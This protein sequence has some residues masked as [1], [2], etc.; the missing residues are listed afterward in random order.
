[1]VYSRLYAWQE[2]VFV[3]VGFF[4]KVYLILFAGGFC[5]VLAISQLLVRRGYPGKWLFILSLF[6]LAVWEEFGGISKY[7]TGS[8]FPFNIYVVTFPAF[9]VSIATFYLLCRRILDATPSLRP[10]DAMHAIMPLYSLLLLLPYVRRPLHL[11]ALMETAAFRAMLYGFVTKAIGYFAVLLGKALR[12]LGSTEKKNRNPL[13]ATSGFIAINFLIFIAWF[14]ELIF[15]IGGIDYIT[16][17]FNAVIILIFLS[18]TRNPDYF[19]RITEQAERFKYARSLIA[20]VDA[21]KTLARLSSLMAQEK[22]Y[23]DPGLCLESLAKRVALGP[24]QLSEL[25]NSKAGKSFLEFVTEY[26]VA[27]AQLLLCN[28]AGR[29]V[30]DIACDVGFNSSSAFYSSFKKIAGMTPT[31]YRDRYAAHPFLPVKR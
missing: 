2:G 25:L 18:G 12:L 16:I 8:V 9:S 30:I 4:L 28:G 15:S 14:I 27:E 1:M 29:K 13:L 21:E 31:N 17:I 19:L 3:S 7:C 5:F 6:S 20:G 10:R 26:R 23:R 11:R 22:T 24:Q